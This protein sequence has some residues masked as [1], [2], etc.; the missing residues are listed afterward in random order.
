MAEPPNLPG[1]QRPDALILKAIGS[2]ASVAVSGIRPA[3]ISACCCGSAVCSPLGETLR[4][5][6]QARGRSYLS[7]AP[8][9]CSSSY[10]VD[11]A[12][13]PSPP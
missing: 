1:S 10:T 11:L 5:L 6:G 13:S 3:M 8:K 7:V 4:V 2:T 9:V 12:G